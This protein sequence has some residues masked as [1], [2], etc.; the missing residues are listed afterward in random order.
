VSCVLFA[1]CMGFSRCDLNP[2]VRGAIIYTIP[3]HPSY[4]LVSSPAAEYREGLKQDRA[5]R[6]GLTDAGVKKKEKKHKKHKKH[7]DKDKKRS[8]DKKVKTR[9]QSLLFGANSVD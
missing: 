4:S 2:A 9:L 3:S 7:K 8:K 1:V 6:L 5:R